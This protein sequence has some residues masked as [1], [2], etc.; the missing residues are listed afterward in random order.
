MTSPLAALRNTPQLTPAQFVAANPGCWMQYYDD[1]PARDPAK[2]LSTRSFD[3]ATVRRKQQS[4]CAVCFSLQAFGESRTKEGLLCYRN[5]G[6]DADLVAP[7][8]KRTLSTEDID[9]RKEDYLVRCI[10]PF[11]VK[12]HWLVETRHGFHAIFRILP[13]RDAAD[14]RAAAALNHRLVRALRGDEKA[15]LLTQVLRVPG[16]YQFKDP[17]HPFLCLLLLNN[18][19]TLVPYDLRIVRDVLD[20]WEESHGTE[21][22]AG[23]ARPAPD[24]EKP[25][26]WKDGLVGVPEGQR[27]ATAASIVG[28][29]LF[30]LPQG[31]WEVAGW[32]GLKE[33]NSRNP[34]PLPER[35]LRTVFEN[36]ARR[37]RNRRGWRAAAVH[38]DTKGQDSCEIPLP[39]CAR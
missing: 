31:L 3:P 6:V 39:S 18:A 33:W 16:T 29:I 32:G 19:R 20:A 12:P 22:I 26:C 9:Q 5:L 2:A 1:T 11:P 13:P 36:I 21:G 34:A 23:P 27:N 30:R 28:K 24:A 38:R 7:R 4:Q 37:E 17:Q 35:E 8:E 14:V 15:A 10:F 25:G